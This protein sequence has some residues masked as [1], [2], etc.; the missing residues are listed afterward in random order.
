VRRHA[1]WDSSFAG[2]CVRVLVIE[3]ERDIREGIAEALELDGHSVTVAENGA[4]GLERARED[5]PQVI[6]LDLMMP[7]MNGWQFL[8]AQQRDPV[9][10]H[11]PVVVVSARSSAP[12]RNVVARLTKPFELVH[13]LSAVEAAGNV[14]A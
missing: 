6:L 1:R 7:V 8:D 10:G 9:L 2:V 3:D 5:H 13:L 12:A 11:I 4:R 14:S